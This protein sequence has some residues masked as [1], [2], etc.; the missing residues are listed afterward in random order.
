MSE[1]ICSDSLLI[2]SAESTK[3]LILRG[4]ADMLNHFYSDFF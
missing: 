2:L 4:S 3:E 1:I